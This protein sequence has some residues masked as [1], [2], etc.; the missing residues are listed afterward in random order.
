MGVNSLTKTV[1]RQRRD[2]D[3]NPYHS[4]QESSPLTTRLTF[5]EASVKKL[6]GPLRK[7]TVYAVLLTS[8]FVVSY[9]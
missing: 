4:A 9:F 2:Y 1:T 7:P 8:N 5:I 6:Q 3:F